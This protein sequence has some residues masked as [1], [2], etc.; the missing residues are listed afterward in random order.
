MGL[1]VVRQ[2]LEDSGMAVRLARLIVQEITRER[3]GATV[4]RTML[5]TL[6]QMMVDLSLY[7]QC[8]VPR[9]IE[10]TREHYER[11]SRRLVSNLVPVQPVGQQSQMDVPMYLE[12]VKR[13]LAEETERTAQYLS[14]STKSSLLAT[15]VR[16]LIE[17]HTDHLL[18][19]SFDE[20]LAQDRVAELSNLYTLLDSVDR[21]DSLKRHW[22]AYI[23]K[24]GT[25][26]VQQPD[27]DV[28]LVT[29]LLD[30]KQRL[31]N[32]LAKSFA[33]SESLAH[34]LREA[35][36][37]FINARRNK[38]TQLIAKFV[39]QC[40][41]TGGRIAPDQNL[42]ALLDRV[43]VLFRFIQGKDMFEAFYKRDLAKRLLTN[44]SASKDAERAMLQRLK[45]E[46]GAGFTNKLEGMFRDI[47]SSEE[48]A[49]KFADN[50]SA[51]NIGA[52]AFHASILAHAFWPTYEPL[53]LVVPKAAEDA[54]SAF[55]EFYSDAHQGRNLQ[56][57]PMLGTCL[58]KV[59]FD[60]G[61]KELALSVV[62]G[63][64]MCLFAEVDELSYAEIQQNTSLDDATLQRTLQSL[65]CG[66]ARVLVKEPKGKNVANTDSFVF[67]KA[68]TSPQARIKISQIQTKGTEK[69]TKDTE[70]R[71]QFD[72]MYKV[73]AA[74]VRIMKARRTLGYTDLLTEL[75]SQLK[76][77]TSAAELKKRID[78]LLERE[79]LERDDNDQSV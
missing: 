60:D 69:E 67:N 66:K 54:Q 17:K 38:P 6:T 23:K 29:E 27:L 59:D 47:E 68:F 8:L 42:D 7:S 19:T 56:W 39:D 45:Q 34:A 10:A 1:A 63:T 35:F 21:L 9:L 26:L 52:M 53:D 15:A 18:T 37:E 33:G 70:E 73:D 30:L 12:H 40:M 32:V 4:D 46:C 20:M 58:L 3:D 14:A 16:E 41:R 49:T 25:A 31:D 22:T 65:A 24:T 78:S 51:A 76:F 61:P 57:Q 48:L 72:R 71:V 55:A 5:R 79:F 13:R 11:E 77:N 62:Q 2:C 74:I 50:P 44:K 75:M 36:E 43:L 64:V 28:A